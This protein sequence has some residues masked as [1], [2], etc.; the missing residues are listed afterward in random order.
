MGIFQNSCETREHHKKDNLRTRYYRCNFQHVV[1]AFEKIANEEDIQLQQKNERYK[2]LYLCAY[3]YEVFVSVVEINPQESS[4]DLKV[5][6][7]STF[8]WGKPEKTVNHI[9]EKLNKI[10]IYKGTSLH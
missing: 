6:Y 2:E 3:D 9:Y 10:L 1:K 8:G 4:V 7:F 5:N